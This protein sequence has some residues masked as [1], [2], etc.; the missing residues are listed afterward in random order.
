MLF[1]DYSSAIQYHC[2][3]QAWD[4]TPGSGPEQLPVQLDP[5][6]IVM[7]IP[8]GQ[9]GKQ[10]LLHF[11]P[12]HWSPTGLCSQTSPVF[13]IHLRLRSHTPLRRQQW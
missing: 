10:E 5:G 7:E 8:G 3:L 6:L 13:L 11:N 1:V 12:Q 4:E 9:N 2:A